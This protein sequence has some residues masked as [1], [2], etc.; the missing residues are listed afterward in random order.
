MMKICLQKRFPF[1]MPVVCV[2]KEMSD[3]LACTKCTQKM[4]TFCAYASKDDEMH[5]LCT[6]CFKTANVIK[7]KINSKINLEIQT[8]KNE[9]RKKISHC[10]FR[11]YCENSYSWHWQGDLRN[12]LTVVISM[13]KDGFYRCGTSVEILRCK[14]TIHFMLKELV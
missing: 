2:I 1:P 11:N 4:H 5:I 7:G 6:L 8:K 13:T 9:F 12:V 3:V 10:Y 14:V